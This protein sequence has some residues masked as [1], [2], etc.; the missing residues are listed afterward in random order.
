M[1]YLAYGLAV[2]SPAA[3]VISVPRWSFQRYRRTF[4]RV[5]CR[6][7]RIIR[8][9][10]QFVSYRVFDRTKIRSVTPI[11]DCPLR[12]RYGL[13]LSA[14]ICS[15]PAVKLITVTARFVQSECL[16]L[17]RVTRRVSTYTSVVQRVTYRVFNRCPCRCVI[18]ISRCSCQDCYIR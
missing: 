13:R 12:Y 11:S 18:T 7:I 15:S 16:G 14:Q 2:E 3:K 10:V 1:S 17:N 4:Y 8:S 9:T 5:R 6:V